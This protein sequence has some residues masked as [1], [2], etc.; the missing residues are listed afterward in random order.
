VT[1]T[2][3]E[4]EHERSGTALWLEARRLKLALGLAFLEGIIVALEKDFTRWTVIII[5]A[6]II[7][8]YVFAGRSLDSDTGRQ[9]AWI[10]AATQAFAILLCVIAL[11]IGSF[12]LIIAGLFAAVAVIL[13]L[14][15]RDRPR[16]TSNKT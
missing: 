9:L 7:A 14:G 5:S 8:F 10:A 4:H 6:P 13:L 12:A 16:R 11:L 1:E 3:A 2:A 15:E